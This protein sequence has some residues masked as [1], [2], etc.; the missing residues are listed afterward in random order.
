[1]ASKNTINV[2]VNTDGEDDNGTAQASN[3]G[4]DDNMNADDSNVSNSNN[5]ALAGKRR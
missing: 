3:A 1:M 2:A 5:D 4:G